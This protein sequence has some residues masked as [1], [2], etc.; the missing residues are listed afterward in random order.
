ML[1]SFRSQTIRS[2]KLSFTASKRS[3][4]GT[5]ALIFRKESIPYISLAV[6]AFALGFQGT[7]LHPWHEHL[8]EQF[9]KIEK[10]IHQLDLVTSEL[11]GKMQR[12]VE[13]GKEVKAKER[14]NVAKSQE[15]LSKL[16]KTRETIA[17]MHQAPT[18]MD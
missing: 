5:L 16:E 10:E 14:E 12:V 8:S 9:D 13:I 4:S 1:P 7:V 6:G 18:P 2:M 3:F 15:I 17:V 11:T